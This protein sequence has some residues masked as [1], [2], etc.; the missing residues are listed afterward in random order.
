MSEPLQRPTDADA[1]WIT[2]ADIIRAAKLVI[3]L[4]GVGAH[5]RARH[6][7][8]DLRLTGDH[9]AAEIWRR[10]AK[11]IEQLQAKAPAEGEKVH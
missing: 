3:W 11:A 2:E 4:R 10:I 9:E 5:D 7:V 8:G 6:R 1:E